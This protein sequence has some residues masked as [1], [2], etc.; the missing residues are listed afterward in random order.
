M[1]YHSTSSVAMC[2]C[3]LCVRE[4]GG[5]GGGGE[6]AQAFFVVAPWAAQSKYSV[7]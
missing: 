3:V 1:T 6:R 2:V 4:G 5:G 7:I